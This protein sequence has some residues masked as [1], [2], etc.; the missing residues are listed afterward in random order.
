VFSFIPDIHLSSALSSALMKIPLQSTSK[1]GVILELL[2]TLKNA[3]QISDLNTVFR[4]IMARETL[5][6]T[7]IGDGI[8]IP[9]GK[10]AGR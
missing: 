2:E 8:A 9:H 7:G 5:M 3:G 4:D 1:E 6:S 10:T